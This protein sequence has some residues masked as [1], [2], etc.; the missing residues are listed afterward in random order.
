MPI[1]PRTTAGEYYDHGVACIRM[2]VA[3]PQTLQPA[4]IELAT[5]WFDLAIETR[6]KRL[7][8]HRVRQQDGATGGSVVADRQC[9]S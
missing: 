8:S 3:L 4:M 9:P 7:A 2:A 6:C 1:T 5:W